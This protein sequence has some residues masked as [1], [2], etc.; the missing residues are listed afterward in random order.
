[1][2]SAARKILEAARKLSPKERAFVVAELVR[3]D[4]PRKS[5]QEWYEEIERRLDDFDVEDADAET[6]YQELLAEL[7][8]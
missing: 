5:D 3:V 4:E 8:R 6:V 1:M 2:T 7:E